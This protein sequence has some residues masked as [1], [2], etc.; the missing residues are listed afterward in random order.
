MHVTT[1]GA[2]VSARTTRART[3]SATRHLALAVIGGALLVGFAV[4]VV[5]ETLATFGVVSPVTDESY[6]LFAV[7]LTGLAGGAF[8][9]GVRADQHHRESDRPRVASSPDE[10]WRGILVFAFVA[11]YVVAG[12]VA[13]I[14]CLA[15]LGASTAVLRGLAAAF[16]GTSVASLTAFLD[17]PHDSPDDPGDD[18]RQPRST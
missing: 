15:R 14:V 7:S 10:R 2:T 11:G 12:S 8:A 6:E 9:A 16:L 18:G 17:L 3:A 5:R 4:V 13:L 1:R